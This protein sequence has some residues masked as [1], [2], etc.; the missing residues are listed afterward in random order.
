MQTKASWEELP[1]LVAFGHKLY[2]T[3]DKSQNPYF[4]S[5]LQGASLIRRVPYPVSGP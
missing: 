2:C 5:P 3:C 4:F 1:Q